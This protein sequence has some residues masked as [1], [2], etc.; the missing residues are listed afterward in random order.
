MLAK[1]I[2]VLF[3]IFVTILF[4]GCYR[5][6]DWGKQRFYQGCKIDACLTVPREHIRTTRVYDQF[7]TVGIFNAMWLSD[8]VLKSYTKLHA[9]KYALNE[10]AEYNFLERQRA[11]NRDLLS[12][13]V[14]AYDPN[15]TTSPFEPDRGK[16]AAW[17]IYLKIEERAY[18]PVFL[19]ELDELEPEY[20]LFFGKDLTNFK[21]IYLVQ[22]SALDCDGNPLIYSDTRSIVLCLNSIKVHAALVWK[23]NQ[24]GRLVVTYDTYGECCCVH[25]PAQTCEVCVNAKLQ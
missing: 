12:F 19:K 8:A 23:I 3:I 9:E 11:N 20:E 22:F 2:Y 10:C 5:M 16:E 18:E 15:A 17:T 7:S 21:T 1:K 25:E 14:L 24:D 6:I 4:S 13:Y